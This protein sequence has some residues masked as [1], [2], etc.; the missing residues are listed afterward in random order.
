MVI[1]KLVYKSK[2]TGKNGAILL[3]F[4][5]DIKLSLALI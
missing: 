3:K 1:W 5:S 4:S 2:L